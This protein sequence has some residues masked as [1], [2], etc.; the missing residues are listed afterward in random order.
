MVKPRVNIIFKHTDPILV[1]A[2]STDTS[3]PSFFAAV[4]AFRVTAASFSLS[5]SAIISV[6]CN[7]CPLTLKSPVKN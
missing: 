3:P 4:K 6:L 1:P 5:C 7:L 2:T